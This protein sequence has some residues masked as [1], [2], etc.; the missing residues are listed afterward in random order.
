[1]PAAT[2]LDAAGSTACVNDMIVVMVRRAALPENLTGG[3][4]PAA[5]LFSVDRGVH[6][7]RGASFPPP[8][9]A[10]QTDQLV[11]STMASLITVPLVFYWTASA[12]PAI[13]KIQAQIS[14][15]NAILQRGRAGLRFDMPSMAHI[16]IGSTPVTLSNDCDAA[17]EALTKDGH[18]LTA[19]TLFV[20]YFTDVQNAK[21]FACPPEAGQDAGIIALSSLTMSDVTLAHE[22][23]HMMALLRPDDTFGHTGHGGK[24]IDG[25]DWS[26]MMWAWQTT[27]ASVYRIRLSLGQ[28]FRMNLEDGS[29]IVHAGLRPVESINCLCNP[30]DTS[31]CPRLSADIFPTPAGTSW[32][33]C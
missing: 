27:S 9:T 16:Q 29:W 14:N 10:A 11:V 30:Y 5:A 15:A 31:V 25:F 8:W 7:E 32:P 4:A 20:A 6:F 2:I 22:L 12:S 17:A 28:A 13:T 19:R 33:A 26:N 3:C 24:I 1:V 18:D 21:A 23:G